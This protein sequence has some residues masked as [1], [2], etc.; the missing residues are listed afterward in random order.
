MPIIE[1]L[2]I[3]LL[4]VLNSPEFDD[5]AGIL[6]KSV[7]YIDE[8]LI[9]IFLINFGGHM[10]DQTWQVNIAGVKE[11][12]IIRNWSETLVLYNQHPLLLEYIDTQT[13]LY[14][15]GATTEWRNLFIDIFEM[16][17]ELAEDRADIL[18]Y[19]FSPQMIKEKSQYGHGLFARGPKTILKIY[20]QCLVK[21][22]IYAYYLGERE[23]SEDDKELKLLQIGDSFTI[24]KNFTFEKKEY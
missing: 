5:E 3:E 6:I 8:D 11:E 18:Q 14:F 13:E 24:G 10:P 23:C 4:S 21:Y 7:E 2:P 9:V 16:V 17:S 1:D 22:G 15:K 19:I 12:R 20:E